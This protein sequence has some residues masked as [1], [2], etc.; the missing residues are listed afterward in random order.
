[1]VRLAIILF[2]ALLIFACECVEDINTPKI[3][4]PDEA[5]NVAFINAISEHFPIK[6]SSNEV[7][8]LEDLEISDA[9]I[10]WSKVASGNTF[11]KVINTQNNTG[12]LNFT[13]ELQSKAY[14][15]IIFYSIKSRIIPLIIQENYDDIVQNAVRFVNTTEIS[16]RNMKFLIPQNDY[17][18][19]LSTGEFS[20]LLPL[21]ISE[22]NIKVY[23]SFNNSLVSE[24]QNSI[25]GY[26]INLL[27]GKILSEC[28]LRA[29]NVK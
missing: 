10:S 24:T 5:A 29:Y 15:T 3:I 18:I 14:Y 1:M 19:E 25:S 28:E 13:S 26:Q 17:S 16:D 2:S 20:D 9:N 8:V 12:I 21:D 27:H 23:E 4:E 22:Y 11:I 6:I 7:Q